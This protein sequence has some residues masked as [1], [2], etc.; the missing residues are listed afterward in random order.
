LVVVRQDRNHPSTLHPYS[1]I[2]FNRAI[3]TEGPDMLNGHRVHW[4]L[5][6]LVVFVQS[7]C[8]T[9][10][11]YHSASEYGEFSFIVAADMRET[12]GADFQTDQYFQGVCKAIR[13]AGR[14]DFMISP[15][16]IDPPQNVANVIHREL[17]DDYQWYP[18]A[19]NHEVETPEDMAWLR[20]WAENGIPGL[21][22]YGPE[23]SELTTYSFDHGQAHFIVL[24]QYYTG[25][26]DTGGDGDIV[27]PLYDWLRYDLEQTDQPFIFVFGHEPIVSVPDMDSGRVRHLGDS[28]D[29]H[30]ENNHRF[31]T[32]LREHKVTAYVC[33]HTHSFSVASINGLTQIDAGHCRG[34]QIEQTASTFLRFHVFGHQCAVEVWRAN[35][36]GE[37]Y[38]L[39]H[40]LLMGRDGHIWMMQTELDLSLKE[41]VRVGRSK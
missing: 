29:A 17:G 18:V 6:F 39:A 31:Q 2:S 21:V 32:L 5:L 37:E 9:T 25:T 16:D 14:G 41:Y 7:G 33:G 38:R 15:G 12:A 40:G 35:E 3:N 24:N 4:I 30:P 11:V 22:R 19:G 26:A 34:K 27:D 36:H 8:S 13:E 23:H 10:P 1:L 20:T 28:L